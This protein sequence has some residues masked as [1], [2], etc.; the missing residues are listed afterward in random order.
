MSKH[1]SFGITI[2]IIK[3]LQKLLLFVFVIGG[4]YATPINEGFEGTTFPPT[5]WSV[6]N[7][8]DA[9]TW[10]RNVSSYSHTGTACAAILW[11]YTAHDDWLITPQLAPTT[12]DATFSFW[13]RNVNSYIDLFN[14]K[15]F[16]SN[17]AQAN[18]TVT[19]ATNVGPGITYTLY[20]YDLTAYIGQYVYLAIQAI[21][22]DQARLCVDDVTAPAIAITPGTEANPFQ[23]TTAAELSNIRSYLGSTNATKHFKL[24]NDIDLTSYLAQGGAGYTLWNTAGWLPVG[25]DV[26]RFSGHFDGNNKTISG[27][28]IDRPANTDMGFFG[29]VG[30]GAIIENTRVATAAGSYVKGWQTTGMLVGYN[31]GTII[32]CSATGS[33]RGQ[34]D[35]CGGLVG[36]VGGS[37]SLYRCFS[38]GDVIGAAYNVGGLA[39][40]NYGIIGNCFSRA[41]VTGQ[42]YLGSLVG[43]QGAGTIANCFGTGFITGSSYGGLLG[44]LVGGS[45]VNS[46]WD[47]QTTGLAYSQGS[48]ASYGKTTAQM[49]TQ[50]TYVGWD[51]AGETANGTGD[52]WSITSTDNSGYP[53]LCWEKINEFR[54]PVLNYPAQASTGIPQSGVNLTWSVIPGGQVPDH[55]NLYIIQGSPAHIFETGYPGQH[56]YTNLNVT[57]FNPVATGGLF[58]NYSEVW[59][60]TVAACSASAELTPNP[61]VQSFTIES[62]IL[63]TDGFEIGNTDASTT[64]ANWTQ[65]LG[66]GTNYWTVNSTNTTFNRS[67]RT[68]SFNITLQFTGNAW[69][70]RPVTLTG[71][72]PYR[73]EL[74]ARQDGATLTNANI[75]IYYGTTGTVAGMTN[76]VTAQMGLTN[77]GY[78][79]ITGSFI[80][81]TTGTYYLGIHGYLNASPYYVSLDDITFRHTPLTIPEAVTQSLPANLA[82]DQSIIPN[83]TWV[84]N[85]GG[86]AAGYRIYCQASATPITP[87][88]LITTDNASPYTFT[89]ALEYSTTYYWMVIATNSFGDAVN[90]TVQS[91]TTWAPVN[92]TFTSAFPPANWTRYSGELDW[93]TTLTANTTLWVQDDWKNVTSPVN[94]SAK[95]NVY[96]SAR[97]GWLI[98]PPIAMTGTGLRLDLEIALTDK[99]NSNS[100]TTDPTG[101][102]G[103]DDR[104]IILIGDGNSWSPANVL[105]EWNNTGSANVYNNIPESG[106]HVFIPLDAYT[107][108]KYIALYGSSSIANADNDLFIDNIRVWT[109]GPNNLTAVSITGT[110]YGL[111]GTPVTHTVTL[112]NNGTAQQTN[113]TVYLKSVSPA[114]TLA[115][116]NVSTPLAS[117]ATTT[118]YITW[119]PSTT[120][121]ENIYGEVVLATDTVPADNAT[122]NLAYYTFAY[123]TGTEID[124]IQISTPGCLNAV[125]NFVGNSFADNHFKLMNNL[126]LTPYLASGGAGHTAWGTAGWLPIGTI[127]TAFY[128]SF[129]GNNKVI[130]GFKIDRSE[131]NYCGLWGYTETG[132][133]IQNTGIETAL[134]SMVKGKITTGMLV[135]YNNGTINNCYARGS[136]RGTTWIGGLVG[137]N[138]GTI[139]RCFSTGDVVGTGSV[140]GLVGTGNGTINNS[141]S[142]A[143][144]GGGSEDGVGGLV[145]YSSTGT[146]TYCYATGAITTTGTKGGLLGGIVTATATVTNCYWDAQTTG[147]TTSYGLVATYGKTTLEMLTQ[148][149]YAGWD[150]D[151]IWNMNPSVNSGYPQLI[152]ANTASLVVPTNVVIQTGLVSGNVI[153][154]WDNTL[155][156]W[157]GI[158]SGTS[159]YDLTYLGWSA[160]NSITFTAGNQDFYKITSG[161]GTPVG[162]EVAE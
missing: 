37:G 9:N 154:T 145:G 139:N 17:N 29:N 153:L 116:L 14:V 46:Y 42:H 95:M 141:Y 115:T 127:A 53:F 20:T 99:D 71:G 98:S 65:V 36:A 142:F 69:L 11:S 21:S 132:S 76:T 15:L 89:T 126:D 61:D 2:S 27:L 156:P 129:D 146:I 151:T 10:D 91:F 140:G 33:V 22:T 77:G 75:G 102:T 128:G 7:G 158:Y 8:G 59:Y 157:Y 74:Y 38:S 124:P 147:V 13:A 155:A 72:Q 135:G 112:Q 159:P 83:L 121:I 119:T 70:F 26:A 111:A 85:G 45:V 106:S 103:V 23:I 101:T 55:Y 43:Y 160:T 28:K 110:S 73:L 109:P 5:G 54:H 34:S 52:Y 113:Y 67:P 62:D 162:T 49:P 93:V 123:G 138:A 94:K 144:T 57:S 40:Q 82:T 117:M 134:G 78:Q 161:I 86:Y 122:T 64:I 130:S 88:T 137:W 108:I 143:S 25:T 148:A 68:G 100:I 48:D 131:T 30:V 107:G 19:L 60:W 133:V 114:L 4:L 90:S 125:R 84:T 44:N 87:T 39:G 18:F 120:L 50:S 51:F 66:A 31:D 79:L 56:T 35:A 32:N 136:V 41:S 92:E 81:A 118:F 58:F 105:R 152:W 97:F 6:I 149:T 12:G 47:I 63:F 1:R 96:G 24:M 3:K 104:F 16:N 150:F 80:P